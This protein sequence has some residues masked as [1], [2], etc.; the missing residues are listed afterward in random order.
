MNPKS[1][2]LKNFVFD[3]VLCFRLFKV[4]RF[5]NL[6]GLESPIKHT[7]CGMNIASFWQTVLHRNRSMF[8]SEVRPPPPP[9]WPHLDQPIRLFKFRSAARV[10]MVLSTRIR[11][12]TAKLI[13]RFVMH[14]I[15][16]HGIFFVSK[17]SF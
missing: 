13:L 14:L 6:V 16:K 5:Q 3:W 12:E 10:I 4:Y 7:L 9:V 15:D 8:A 17:Y 11:I 2:V 1:A